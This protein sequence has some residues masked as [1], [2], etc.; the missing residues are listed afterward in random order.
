MQIE[1][2]NSF[3]LKILFALL[4]I[5]PT[6]SLWRFCTVRNFSTR[7][8][9]FDGSNLCESR[10]GVVNISIFYF[11]KNIPPRCNYTYPVESVRPT[12]RCIRHIAR[13]PCLIYET[14]KVILGRSLKLFS[15]DETGK[16]FPRRGES[17]DVR[18]FLATS[19][20]HVDSARLLSERDITVGPGAL[21]LDPFRGRLR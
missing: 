14:R 6:T 3:H 20:I 15:S 7:K 5:F 8:L 1:L 9:N 4:F 2:I 10:G 11:S 21:L 13:Y 17:G 12:S 18:F 19:V 16:V